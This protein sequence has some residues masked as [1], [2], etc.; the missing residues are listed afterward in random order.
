[1]RDSRRGNEEERAGGEFGDELEL[2]KDEMA[3]RCWVK[4]AQ[5]LNF[6]PAKWTVEAVAV[7]VCRDLGAE[8]EGTTGKYTPLEVAF[9]VW[10]SIKEV[11]CSNS[12]VLIYIWC[13]GLKC[14]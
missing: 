10:H 11:L 6:A 1:M 4:L 12:V 3:T 14:A 13:P 7:E 5:C 2:F 9:E 8:V